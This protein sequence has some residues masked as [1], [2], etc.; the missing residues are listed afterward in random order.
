MTN[1]EGHKSVS[2]WVTEAFEQH[3]PR[4]SSLYYAVVSRTWADR[5]V[6]RLRE[7]GVYRDDADPPIIDDADLDIDIVLDG[8]LLDRKVRALYEHSSQLDGL[9]SAF[10][11]DTLVEA[12]AAESFR[13][14]PV[15]GGGAR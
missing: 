10:G 13:R 3:A 11:R 14:A 15:E 5:Y 9:I 6:P 7:L 12:F 8:E 2:H 1:H 4:G